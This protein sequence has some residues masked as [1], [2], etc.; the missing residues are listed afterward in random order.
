MI[1]EFFIHIGQFNS[2]GMTESPHIMTAGHTLPWLCLQLYH[3]TYKFWWSR[4]YSFDDLVWRPRWGSN[5]SKS[6]LPARIR[7][8]SSTK[9]TFLL[10]DIILWTGWFLDP[11]VPR[12]F[13]DGPSPICN[14]L[15][16]YNQSKTTSFDQL[17]WKKSLT[18]NRFYF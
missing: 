10:F 16:H 18:T 8:W 1:S 7:W 13:Y 11:S 5:L 4:V 6:L 2:G 17:R 15:P 3:F 9:T 12:A 14:D